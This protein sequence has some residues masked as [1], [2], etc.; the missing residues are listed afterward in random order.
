MELDNTQKNILLDWV[1]DTLKEHLLRGDRDDLVEWANRDGSDLPEDSEDVNDSTQGNEFTLKYIF[2]GSAQIAWT[3]SRKGAGKFHPGLSRDDPRNQQ[4]NEE[5]MGSNP[6]GKDGMFKFE[7]I[8]YYR[9]DYIYKRE[10]E[11]AGPIFDKR[12]V[13]DRGKNSTTK[14]L[15]DAIQDFEKEMEKF[16]TFMD[17]YRAGGADQQVFVQVKGFSR[18]GTTAVAFVKALSKSRYRDQI[19]RIECA[20]F[21][22]VHGG[23]VG[24][25]GKNRMSKQPGVQDIGVT[26]DH[27]ATEDGSVW[28][29]LD[30]ESEDLRGL[31]DLNAT[32]GSVRILP[33]R[34]NHSINGFSPQSVRGVKTV[35]IVYGDR[36]NHDSGQY[37]EFTYDGNI[38]KGN[39]WNQLPPGLWKANS[40]GASPDSPVEVVQITSP[41]QLQDFFEE[42]WGHHTRANLWAFGPATY[43]YITIQANMYYNNRDLEILTV[44]KE[45]LGYNYVNEY[46]EWVMSWRSKLDPNFVSRNA[47]NLVAGSP[48]TGIVGLAS[49]SVGYAKSGGKRFGYEEDATRTART[50]RKRPQAVRAPQVPAPPPPNQDVDDPPSYEEVMSWEN[51]SPPQNE[52]VDPESIEPDVEIL[53]QDE[54]ND[55][56]TINFPPPPEPPLERNQ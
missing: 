1:A 29:E 48:H 34:T 45:I 37:G 30:L 20:F 5:A 8:K 38:L 26:D 13:N 19:K 21:D 17:Q 56:G 25:E 32:I 15:N 35:C 43:D 52:D 10:V 12:G 31:V 4:I 55:D 39:Q 50:T 42:L 2:G 22:P 51:G 40:T 28:D 53:D 27:S 24:F 6:V 14:C 16:A 9:K 36:A 7:K 23:G 49:S 47:A 54:P 11:Y 44:C 46:E 41:G 33:T 18:G 3:T